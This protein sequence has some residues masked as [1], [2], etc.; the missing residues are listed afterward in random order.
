[1]AEHSGLDTFIA[2][3]LIGGVLGAGAALLFAPASGK[4]TRE[5]LAK[6][7][8]LA[9]ESGKGEVEKLREIVREELLK[10]AEGKEALREAVQAGVKTFKEHSKSTSGAQKP[11]EV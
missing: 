6:Q 3:F 10:L 1:M 7:A 4:E 2:G 11:Q 8:S 9:L 5:Y